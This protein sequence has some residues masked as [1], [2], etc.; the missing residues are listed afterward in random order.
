MMDSK[1]KE[2]RLAM[3]EAKNAERVI[4]SRGKH[5]MLFGHQ[6]QLQHVKSEKYLTINAL[7]IAEQDRE[8]MKLTLSTGSV[9]SYFAINP[10]YRI[11]SQVRNSRH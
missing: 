10:V 2:E 8:C 3:E 4:S 7:K 11:Q 1:N 9:A 5:A 6:L